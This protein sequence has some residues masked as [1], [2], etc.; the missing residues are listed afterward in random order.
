MTEPTTSQ[1]T[2]EAVREIEARA[3]AGMTSDIL[4]LVRDWRAMRARIETLTTEWCE[5]GHARDKHQFFSDHDECY[6]CDQASDDL[7]CEWRPAPRPNENATLREQLAEQRETIKFWQRHIQRMGE[8]L[9]TVAMDLEVEKAVKE[10][11]SQLAQVTSERD[12]ARRELEM[13]NTLTDYHLK[14]EIHDAIKG[15]K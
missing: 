4:A 11:Q 15:L 2:E 12:E 10:L 8:L 9:G 7:C 1:L 5:C 13:L 14:P 6:E 3:G